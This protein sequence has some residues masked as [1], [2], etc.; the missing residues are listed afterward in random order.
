MPV[1]VQRFR[2]KIKILCIFLCTDNLFKQNLL[3]EILCFNT[4]PNLENQPQK[5][6]L[7]LI[8]TH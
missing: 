5:S 2:P 7:Y 6:Q 4:F 8:K 1:K 3:I